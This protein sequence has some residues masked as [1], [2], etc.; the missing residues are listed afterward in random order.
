MSTRD[1]VKSWLLEKKLIAIVRGIGSDKL[2]D[3]ATALMKG[4][5]S[6]IEVTFQQTKPETWKDT[7]AGILGIQKRLGDKVLAGAGTVLRVEQV[8]M[9]HDAGAKYIISPNIDIE[10]IEKTLALGMVS[11]PGCMTPS[12]IASAYK[13]GADFVKVFPASVLGPSYI[14]AIRAPLGHIPLTAVGGITVDNAKD[15][16]NAGCCGLG[17]GGNIVNKDWI[18]A[19]DFEKIIALANEY[20]Q[21]IKQGNEK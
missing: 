1:A 18:E 14:K 5:I 9:A 13:A 19:G 21:A 6:C 15:F 7:L 11:M 8:Q 17:I 20:V 16:I 4:G 12:E 10:V 3:L 2:P